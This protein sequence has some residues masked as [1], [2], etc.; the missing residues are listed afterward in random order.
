METFVI[1]FIFAFC[2]LALFSFIIWGAIR[3]AKQRKILFNAAEKYL[4]S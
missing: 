1:L 2:P 3:R 4:K